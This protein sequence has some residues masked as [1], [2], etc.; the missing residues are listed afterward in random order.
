MGVAKRC[1]FVAMK[2]I[3]FGTC[4]HENRE[5]IAI[6]KDSISCYLLR[7]DCFWDIINSEVR[8]VYFD[9]HLFFCP[10]CVNLRGLKVWIDFDRVTQFDWTCFRSR[11]Y[12]HNSNSPNT[13]LKVISLDAS[14][15]RN[16][17][18]IAYNLGYQFGW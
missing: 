10:I 8:Q 15:L 13:Q 6:T 14:W 17:S 9:N 18:K 1:E 4:C 16:G 12:C 7:I 5:H 11:I 3:H 2:N